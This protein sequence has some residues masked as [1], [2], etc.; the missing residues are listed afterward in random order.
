[1]S[2]PRGEFT[3][4]AELEMPHFD[5]LSGLL[6]LGRLGEGSAP[7]SEPVQPFLVAAYGEIASDSPAAQALAPLI[8]DG[9]WDDQV[10]ARYTGLSDA[11]RLDVLVYDTLLLHELTHRCDHLTSVGGALRRV[12][13]VEETRRLLQLM[14]S[15]VGDH[16]VKIGK[17]LSRWDL[18]GASPET[19]ELHET[20]LT[21]WRELQEYRD[22]LPPRRV[23]QT[24]EA[25]IFS[26][27]QLDLVRIQ[28]SDGYPNNYSAALPIEYRPA[29]YVR[30]H[31]AVEARAVAQSLRRLW[32][33]FQHRP[34]L[35]RAEIARYTAWACVAGDYRFLFDFVARCWGHGGLA[36]ALRDL[37]WQELP[38]MAEHVAVVGWLAQSGPDLASRLLGLLTFYPD[39]HK[40]S[41]LF[42]SAELAI[43]LDER[44][45]NEAERFGHH[46]GYPDERAQLALDALGWAHDRAAEL[47]DGLRNHARALTKLCQE[48]LGDLLRQQEDIA[49]FPIPADPLTGNPWNALWKGRAVD[50]D[51]LL[52]EGV[53]DWFRLRASLLNKYG[54]DRGK[55]TDWQMFAE[56]WL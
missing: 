29:R 19:R 20:Q 3:R 38:L 44:L 49:R 1:M 9:Y 39:H 42:S 16:G 35:G 24:G 55:R 26:E 36:A 11:H 50:N 10:L 22:L 47:P 25:L 34:D 54:S 48:N 51:G 30:P 17:S 28:Y 31:A 56:R 5:P 18:W 43:A 52:F 40:A 37:D 27:Q 41:R 21:Y 2:A 33:R 23:Q 14:S 45:Q 7:L 6:Q 15:I 4:W 13:V 53:E 46:I 32:F 12:L 8:G